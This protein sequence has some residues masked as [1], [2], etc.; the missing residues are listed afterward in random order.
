MIGDE[1]CD[2][3]IRTNIVAMHRSMKDMVLAKSD[4]QL[5]ATE[6]IVS[7][8]EQDVFDSFRVISERFLGNKHDVEAAHKAFSDWKPI[9]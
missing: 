8:Y 6:E 4:E 9:R 7:E 1:K 5:D 3:D 2:L